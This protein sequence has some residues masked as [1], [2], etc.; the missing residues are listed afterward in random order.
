MPPLGDVLTGLA[1]NCWSALGFPP[2]GWCADWACQQ[3]LKCSWLSTSGWC[4]CFWC[5]QSRVY[6]LKFYALNDFEPTLHFHCN[7]WLGLPASAEVLHAVGGLPTSGWCACF[8]TIMVPELSNKCWC[9]RS[10]V[11]ILNV[12]ALYV[13]LLANFALKMQLLNCLPATAELLASNCW[14]AEK[15]KCSMLLNAQSCCSAFHFWVMPPL[16]DV[17]DQGCIFLTFMHFM[18]KGKLFVLGNFALKRMQ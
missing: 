2:P 13:T 4:A 9:A 16:G 5:A 15:L 8:S 17:L 3:L 18:V 11:Y 14:N 6:I 12:Y 7:G 10:W 1:S